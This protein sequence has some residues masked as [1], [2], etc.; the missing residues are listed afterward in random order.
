MLEVLESLV[1]LWKVLYFGRTRFVQSWTRRL[2]GRAPEYPFL[3]VST[4]TAISV[5]FARVSLTPDRVH[6]PLRR[7]RISEA[8]LGRGKLTG[9][10]L[11][12][13]HRIPSRA[14]YHGMVLSLHRL[15][16]FNE[17]LNE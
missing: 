12:A 3:T 5:W 7:S 14:I 1:V 17:Q 9:C 4:F 13:I 8:E 11:S 16:L 2:D 6:A 10:S 15:E